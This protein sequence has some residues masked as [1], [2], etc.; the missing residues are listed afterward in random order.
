MQ[1]S[2]GRN[3]IDGLVEAL[4]ILLEAPFPC[5]KRSYR[6]RGQHQEGNEA[7]DDVGLFDDVLKDKT[8]GQPVIQIKED[9]YMDGGIHEG[10]QSQS[11]A[12][13]ERFFPTEKGVV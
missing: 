13:F 2:N 3:Q 1:D 12:A 10:V 9:Q 8:P 5:V 6:Q 7:E 11:A 4:P